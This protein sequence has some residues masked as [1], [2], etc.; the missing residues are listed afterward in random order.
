[1]A[2][3]INK[4]NEV[5]WGLRR[6]E[7]DLPRRRYQQNPKLYVVNGRWKFRYWKDSFKDGKLVRS[8]PEVDLGPAP[9]EEGGFTKKGAVSRGQA[10]RAK[11][12]F[13]TKHDRE[14]AKPTAQISF[15]DYYLGPYQSHLAATSRNNQIQAESLFRLHIVPALG[16]HTLKDITKRHVQELITQKVV[17][18]LSFATVKH[19]RKFVSAVFL[20]AK[21][22]HTFDGENPAAHVKLPP[23]RRANPTPALTFE[24]AAFVLL[25]L[26]PKYDMYAAMSTMSLCC[27]PN[28]AEML[29][30]QWRRLNLNEQIVSVDGKYLPPGT[31][32]IAENYTAD[33]QKETKTEHRDRILPLPD[34]LIRWLREWQKQTQFNKPDDT[35][36]A[37]RTGKPI[38]Y[39]N[40]NNRIFKTLSHAVE[41]D[42]TWN[43]FRHSFRAFMDELRVPEFRRKLLMGHS[44]QDDIGDLYGHATL[45]DLRE[46][47]NQIAE[48]IQAARALDRPAETG[49]QKVVVIR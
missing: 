23:K 33:Q 35:V 39:N 32:W 18:G 43:S 8:R 16:D 17:E 20:H 26:E 40:A 6:L 4:S 13:L 31:V 14:G 1:M 48:R 7:F 15:R 29:G 49:A 10:E 9:I 38:D 25:A 2:A 42:F 28:V 22:E 47:V 12:A 45:D 46:I 21:E 19:I 27:S 37:A 24:K 11:Q 30:I 44:V 34:V 3:C 41:V 5:Y 36:F